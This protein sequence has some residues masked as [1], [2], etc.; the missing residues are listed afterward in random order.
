MINCE[1]CGLLMCWNNCKYNPDKSKQNS[2]I[3]CSE[4]LKVMC[5]NCGWDNS[6]FCRTIFPRGDHAGCYKAVCDDCNRKK[7][8]IK[9]YGED[10]EWD[11]GF[12]AM[13]CDE[14]HTNYTRA[15]QN[16]D[17]R[18]LPFCGQAE[19]TYCHGVTCQECPYPNN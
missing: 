9:R 19:C 6:D 5:N 13:W 3:F 12:L 8:I 11:Y 1:K 2:L 18:V 16:C 17:G 7:N 4:C 14:C 10:D 15:C